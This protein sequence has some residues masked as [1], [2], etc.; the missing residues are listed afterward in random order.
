MISIKKLLKTPR[1]DVTGVESE[2][3]K[4]FPYVYHSYT[5]EPLFNF[6]IF[7]RDKYQAL[8]LIILFGWSERENQW[9][10]EPVK[11]RK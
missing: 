9:V 10:F 11:V 8:R 2:L 1:I 3:K 5:G 6:R 7:C 4:V